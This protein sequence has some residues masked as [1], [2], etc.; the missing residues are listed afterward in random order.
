MPPKNARTRAPGAETR[1]TR[2]APPSILY[3]DLSIRVDDE[4]LA[5]RAE[6][7]D[8]IPICFSSEQPVV[9]MDWWEGERYL[10]VLDHSPESV[11]LAYARDGLPFLVEHT[12]RDLVGI[13]EDVTIDADRRGRGMLKPSKSQRGQ[14]I[15]QD[16]RDGIRKKVS[17]GYN[18]GDTYTQTGGEQEGSMPTRRFT[19]WTPMEVSSVAIPADVTVGI[20]RSAD[21]RTPASPHVPAPQARENTMSDKDKAAQNGAADT[22]GG[23]AAAPAAPAAGAQRDL[24]K[25]YIEIRKMCRASNVDAK[26]EESFISRG[27]NPDQVARELF[28]RATASGSTL[29]A[30]AD[31]GI[32]EGEAREY[33]FGRAL[34]ALVNDD[35]RDAGYEREVSQ[36]LQKRLG[37][38]T[39]G[40]LVPT[41]GMNTRTTMSAGVA[42]NG[43][44]TV[45][46]QMSGSLIE[47][48]RN[49]SVIDRMGPTRLPGL[50][51]T[52]PIPRQTGAG[53]AA[54][55]AE[56]PGAPG[57]AESNQTFDQV[58]L[59]PKNILATQSY[60]KQ[61]FAQSIFAIDALTREDLTTILALLYDLQCLHGAGGAN[62]ITGIYAAAGVN[63]VAFGGA[64]TYPKLVDMESAIEAGNA[65][66]GSMGYV[67]TPEVKGTAKKTLEFAVNGA[68]KIW[69]GTA[70]EGEMNGYRA[71]ASNQVAKNLGAGV[72]EHGIVFGAFSQ[73]L[74]A[75]WGAID[76]TVD[77]YTRAREGAVQITAHWLAD[78]NLRHGQS[79][80]KGTGLTP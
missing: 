66:L 54:M 15:A 51:G 31:L 55:Q 3:R 69:T 71:F 52:V 27:L 64:I 22:N 33:N 56:V 35:F 28:N 74:A 39:G 13:V 53:T 65:N 4:R 46:A 16:I 17:F 19:K 67:T 1:D 79:F 76:V 37:R 21:A 49:K 73:A 60:S 42:G 12:T 44:N 20:G 43:G 11:D 14:E 32:S 23:G 75:D 70:E 48:L 36:Q 2:E 8:R 29:S 47:L 45:P 68:S 30:P 77:P 78:F 5:A 59:S 72:N 34:Q 9:R 24:A 41:F 57:V 58:V 6:G 25:E 18:P 26:T 40:L 62:N 63:A 80:S 10:E 38:S 7:D 61:L 50:T